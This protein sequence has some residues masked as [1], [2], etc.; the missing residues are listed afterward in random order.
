MH[1]LKIYLI[2]YMSHNNDYTKKCFN[3]EIQKFYVQVSA[4]ATVKG[5]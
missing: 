1:G 2:I 4:F 5:W 3:T